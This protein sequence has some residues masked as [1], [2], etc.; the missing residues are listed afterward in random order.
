RHVASPKVAGLFAFDPPRVMFTQRGMPRRLATQSRL[1]YAAR[2]HPQSPMWMGFA[3]QQVSGSGPA[4]VTTVA[5]NAS[6]KR[7]APV[8]AD[9]FA[10]ASIQ[11]LSHV[12]LDLDQF[13]LAGAER[14]APGLRGRGDGDDGDGTETGADN[15]ETFLQRVQYMFRS[16]PPPSPGFADQL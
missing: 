16:T 14:R 8:S 5:G 6:A 15:D 7:T 9:N 1:S 2:I 10:N 11:P 12:I 4:A 13:Y 3:D